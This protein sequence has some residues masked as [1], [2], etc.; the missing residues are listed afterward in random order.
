V[1][2]DPISGINLTTILVATLGAVVLLA[3]YRWFAGRSAR[4]V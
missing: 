1:P 4:R 3:I 2:G